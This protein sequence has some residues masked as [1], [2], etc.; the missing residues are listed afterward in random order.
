MLNQTRATADLLGYLY[1]LVKPY[2]LYKCLEDEGC[3]L[4]KENDVAIVRTQASKC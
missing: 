3:N 1:L 4:P 2:F